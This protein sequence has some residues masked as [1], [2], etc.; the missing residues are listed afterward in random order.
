MS[1][2]WIKKWC[3]VWTSLLFPISLDINYPRV[4]GGG[5]L[6]QDQTPPHSKLNI[7][8]LMSTQCSCTSAPGP[9]D[10]KRPQKEDKS[11]SARPWLMSERDQKKRDKRPGCVTAYRVMQWFMGLKPELT[12]SVTQVKTALGVRYWRGVIKE[13]RR[14]KIW[15]AL[16]Q[17]L[18]Y[19]RQ[20]ATDKV[21]L[22]VRVLQSTTRRHTHTYTQTQNV[23]RQWK[24]F[25]EKAFY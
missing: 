2:Y 1:F 23:H 10:S 12:A 18:L 15:R 19:F 20:S 21:I 22:L 6:N 25:F 13:R 16:T 7:A 11:R 3:F 9:F 24:V 17:V 4:G 5:H 8:A 14:R